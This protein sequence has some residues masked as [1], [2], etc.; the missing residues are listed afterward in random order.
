M[1][2]STRCAGLHVNIVKGVSRGKEWPDFS[3]HHFHLRVCQ[4]DVAENCLSQNLFVDWSHVN[5]LSH[6]FAGSLRWALATC[7]VFETFQWTK[8]EWAGPPP[9]SHFLASS[10]RGNLTPAFSLDL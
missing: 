10:R 5:K 3:H 2:K 7:D 4:S 9:N 8:V 1:T 6:P